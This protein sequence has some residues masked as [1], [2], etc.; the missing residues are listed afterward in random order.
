MTGNSEHEGKAAGLLPSFCLETLKK[1]QEFK[2]AAAGP[3]FSTPSFTMLRRPIAQ[4]PVAQKPVAQES[5][6][7][8]PETSGLARKRLR[9]GFTVTKRVGNSVVR[10]R[11][12]RRLREAV[13]AA[14][15]QFP[16]IEMDLVILARGEVIG[17]GFTELVADIGRAVAALARRGNPKA[18]R[19][20]GESAPEGGI[21]ELL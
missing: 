3:R 17:I 7:Q 9:F 19:G 21:T 18:A 5:V 14:S 8:E 15:P 10:N 2:Q 4:E 1:R 13:R 6:A 16:D 20:R 12:R 11:I